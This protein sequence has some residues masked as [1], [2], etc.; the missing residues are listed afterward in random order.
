LYLNNCNDN[1][2]I[3]GTIAKETPHPVD[4][5]LIA[6]NTLIRSQ[7]VGNHQF[8]FCVS[9]AI[10]DSYTIIASTP[11]YYTAI[12]LSP[13]D[14]PVINI[15][16]LL[17]PVIKTIPIKEINGSTTIIERTITVNPI[18]GQIILINKD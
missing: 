16:I 3:A 1:Q 10:F 4:L 15:N 11:D 8:S 13:P 9:N 6:N 7:K 17:Q 5:F 18:G 2:F 12:G 14:F